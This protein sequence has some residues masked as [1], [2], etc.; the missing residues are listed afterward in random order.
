MPGLLTRVEPVLDGKERVGS[1]GTLIIDNPD[2]RNAMN[3]AMYHAVPNAVETLLEEPDLRCV[4]VR[5]SGTEAFCAGS[6]ISEFTDRRM[7]QEAQ[8]Y[9]RAE[10]L[11]WEA[12]ASIPV[13]VLAA[14]HGPCRGGGVAIAMHADLRFAAVNASFSIPPA[15]LGLAYPPEA[16]RRLI[17]LVGPANAKMLLLAA[18]VLDAEQAARIGL[19]QEVHPPDELDDRVNTFAHEL[20]R[21]SPLS[22][23]AAKATVNAIA[24]HGSGETVPLRSLS[25]IAA[26]AIAACYDSLDFKEGIQAFMQKRPA[27]FRGL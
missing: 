19:V 21:L 7:G 5:G 10:H 22:L 12:L 14:I 9:D 6:D 3:A 15:R 26:D 23:K 17:E 16:T 18:P 2:R 25:P 11:S 27:Q 8:G 13:P 1:I 4:I 20:A 24:A